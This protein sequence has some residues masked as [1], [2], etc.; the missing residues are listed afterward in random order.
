VRPLV[1]SLSLAFL[2]S[3]CLQIG[4]GSGNGGGGGSTPST[5]SDAGA[6]AMKG[7]AC[8]RDKVTGV[9]LCAGV[10]G[11][12]GLLVDPEAFPGCGFKP[13]TLDLQCLCGDE[14]CP[15]GSVAKT[16]AEA[17]YQLAEGNAAITCSQLGSGVCKLGPK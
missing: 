12:P 7:V 15:M 17:Q 16:C 1:V 9:E 14:L 5:P 6:D 8:G 4:T 2:C 13:G 11:C 3:G 10:S